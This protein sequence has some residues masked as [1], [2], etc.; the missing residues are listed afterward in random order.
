MPHQKNQFPCQYG[1]CKKPATRALTYLVDPPPPYALSKDAKQ[2]AFCDKHDETEM[3]QL[4]TPGFF[5]VEGNGI[6]VNCTVNLLTT[7]QSRMTGTAR[8]PIRCPLSNL[9]TRRTH[10]SSLSPQ[11]LRS[12]RK[13]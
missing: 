12:S 11:T 4:Q 7:I 2:D 10:A 1:G 13:P 3:L 6:E 5:T 8:M 9:R